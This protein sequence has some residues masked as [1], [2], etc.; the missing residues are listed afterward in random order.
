MTEGIIQRVFDRK[1][2][3]MVDYMTGFVIEEL[4][5]ELVIELSKELDSHP[6]GK[7]I[8]TSMFRQWLIGDN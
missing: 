3:R 5:H 1:T 8:D 4:K 6:F 2:K 7:S